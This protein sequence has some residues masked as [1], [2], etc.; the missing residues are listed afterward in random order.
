MAEEP[1]FVEVDTDEGVQELP[2]ED[3]AAYVLAFDLYASLT[4]FLMSQ[5]EEI[6]DFMEGRTAL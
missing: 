6:W 5:T 4:K 1:Y 3:Q 2:P